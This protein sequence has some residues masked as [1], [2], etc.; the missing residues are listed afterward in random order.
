MDNTN[1]V[2]RRTIQLLPGVETDLFFD[3]D[4]LDTR[5]TR[6]LSCRLRNL[7]PQVI[8]TITRYTTQGGIVAQDATNY[9]PLPVA[10]P[11]NVLPQDWLNVTADTTRLTATSILGSVVE[12]EARAISR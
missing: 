9:G 10:P 4:G 11:G 5:T 7:G 6:T 12:V 2:R 3:P 8:G 1:Q